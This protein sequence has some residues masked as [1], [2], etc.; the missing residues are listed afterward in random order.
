MWSSLKDQLSGNLR[1]TANAL[2]ITEMD[3][4]HVLVWVSGQ[5][6]VT[7]ILVAL[8]VL[9]YVL[10]SL[11]LKATLGRQQ[12]LNSLYLSLKTG[13]Q[14]LIAL[15]VIV[16]IVAQ[17]G[18]DAII[19]KSIARGGLMALGFYVAWVLVARTIVGTLDRHRIDPSLEQLLKNSVSVLFLVLGAV[20]VM[21]QFGFDVWS[22]IAGLG[23]VGIAVGFAA[24]STLSNFIAGVTLLI[25]RPFR[26]GDWVRINDQEGKVQKIAFRTTWLRTRDNIFTMIP[27]DSV[28]SSEIINFTAEG[29]TRIRIQLGIAYKE[30][31]RA[32]RKEILPILEAHPNVLKEPG[33]V[34][35]VQMEGLGDSSVDL[36]AL[37]WILPEDIDIQPRISAEILEQIKERLDE[38]GI[39]IPFPHLQLFIDEAKG[40]SPLLSPL[41]VNSGNGAA[42]NET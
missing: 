9:I 18:G 29:P 37:A 8:A 33:M 41:R 22:I 21:A 7:L 12:R 3:W 6:L 28:A 5:L 4:Q 25:E 36:V 34:P 31:A 15:F 42:A 19:L 23:I 26:I 38:V 16:A 24:Q 39:E 2:G 40:L 27:N 20:T 11:V 14:Y 35:R 13:L 17:Y 30:T 10:F 1:D 32:A